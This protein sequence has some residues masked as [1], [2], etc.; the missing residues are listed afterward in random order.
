MNRLHPAALSR[1]PADVARPGYDRQALRCGIVHLGVGAFQRAH[2]AAATEA[3]VQTSGDLRWGI[4]GV[5]LRHA[6]TRDALAPQGGLFTLALRD[7]ADDGT[8]RETLQIIGTLTEVLV[9]PENPR[10]VLERIATPTRASSASPSLK[11]ATT[12]TPLPAPCGWT[13][14]TSC[15]TWRT[16]THRA[17]PSASWHVGWKCACN[18]ACLR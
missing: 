12:T 8:A 5:S 7:A 14:P 17:A 2:L 18:G 15:T 16:P 3:A 13:T 6:D 10:A 11:R 1:L 4:A 9:A